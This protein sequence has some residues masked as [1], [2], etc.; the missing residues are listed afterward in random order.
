MKLCIPTMDDLGLEGMPS[1]HFG[2]APFLTFVDSETGDVETVRN[3]GD[4]HVHGACLPLDHLGARTT[5]AVLCRGL[6]KRALS[7]L[8]GG[9]IDVYVT[10]EKDVGEALEAFK[11][12]RLRQ[13]TAEE[14]CQGHGHGHG[15]SQAPPRGTGGGGQGRGTGW[16]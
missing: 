6:G 3:G 9:G 4:H 2:S 11:A 8:Q 1:D 7:R 16:T 10:L 14:A 5:D 12:G 13:L 15:H